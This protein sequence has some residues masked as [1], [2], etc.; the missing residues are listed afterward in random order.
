[1]VDI[2]VRPET[3]VWEA[4]YSAVAEAERIAFEAAAH[5]TPAEHLEVQTVANFSSFVERQATSVVSEDGH[6]MDSGLHF[7][8]FQAQ[9][10]NYPGLEISFDWVASH[11][12]ET[13]EDG[14]TFFGMM[15][16]SQQ[17][18]EGRDAISY[19]VI[20]TPEG[21]MTI[22]GDAGRYAGQVN[23]YELSSEY[24]APVADYTPVAGLPGITN[25]EVSDVMDFAM[26]ALGMNE[27]SGPGAVGGK[28]GGIGRASS[29]LGAGSFGAGGIGSS[30]GVGSGGAGGSE[31]G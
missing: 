16:F 22:E 24:G 3:G 5:R 21:Q 13:S 31:A 9:N 25:A 20:E 14:K 4:G 7:A 26:D 11:S 18:D 29:E 17:Q 27:Q 2:T 28:S 19:A 1:M 23:T 15:L 30:V 12:R 8:T 6:E 10:D